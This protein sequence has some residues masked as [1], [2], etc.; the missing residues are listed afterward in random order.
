MT[1]AVPARVLVAHQPA[2]LPW[3]GYFSR[4]LDVDELVLLD[5]VQFSER[6]WQHRN[7][8]RNPAA[9]DKRARLTVP[10]CHRF[11]Q[12]INQVRLADEPWAARHWR[13]LEHIYARAPYWPTHRERL[14]ALYATPWERLVDLDEALTRFLLDGLGLRVRLVRS[15]SLAP[16]GV[17]TAMLADLCRRTGSRALRVGVGA[18]G[19]LDAEVLA[20]CGVHVEVAAYTHPRYAGGWPGWAPGLSALDLLLFEG[21]RAVDVLRAGARLETREPV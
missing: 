14:A 9:T 15:S 16:A 6:G 2:Y 21:P 20:A 5:H 17:R 4:L 19:Y 1:A 10:V 7:H 18:L 13:T 11:G 8:I 12:S 3:Q